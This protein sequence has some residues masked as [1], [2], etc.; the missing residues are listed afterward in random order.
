M[1]LHFLPFFSYIQVIVNVIILKVKKVSRSSS[2]LQKTL[3]LKRLVSNLTFNS[4][5]L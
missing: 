1:L 5:I 3:L 2:P 4:V